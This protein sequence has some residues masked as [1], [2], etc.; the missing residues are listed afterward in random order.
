MD[1]CVGRVFTEE[2]V[3]SGSS[4]LCGVLLRRVCCKTKPIE[5]LY[6]CTAATSPCV[7]KANIVACTAGKGVLCL[8]SLQAQKPGPSH[9]VAYAEV[10]S[11]VV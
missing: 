3:G 8:D 11:K 1:S 7:G 4:P 6:G 10:L 2:L 5:W 9:D